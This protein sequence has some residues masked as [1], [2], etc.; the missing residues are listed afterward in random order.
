MKP[1]PF[2][3]AGPVIWFAAILVLTSI[4]SPGLPDMPVGHVDKMLHF[5]MYLPLGFLVMRSIQAGGPAAI[6]VALVLCLAAAAVDELH[7]ALIPGRFAQLYDFAADGAGGAAGII[8]F[9]VK[10]RIKR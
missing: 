6:A 3:Y 9:I 7:Q 8:I 2:R 5:F 10:N 4:P 1:V